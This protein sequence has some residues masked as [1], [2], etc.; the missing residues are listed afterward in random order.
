[1]F[2][3]IYL[4]HCIYIS[5]HYNLILQLSICP[6]KCCYL[7]PSLSLFHSL[8]LSLSCSVSSCCC[9]ASWNNYLVTMCVRTIVVS[10]KFIID[11]PLPF[12]PFSC[13]ETTPL[14]G[15]WQN[16]CGAAHFTHKQAARFHFLLPSFHLPSTFL[17]CLPSSAG[18]L[19]V[20]F[21]NCCVSCPPAKKGC[22]PFRCC[23][24]F[25][26]HF[27]FHIHIKCLFHFASLLF[28][29]HLE[30]VCSAEPFG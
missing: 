4:S 20:A 9:G 6:I 19:P 17:L 24:F 5:C 11:N 7:P 30:C 21:A 2:N 10:N 27:P 15:I 22:F 25:H 23:C 3:W 12:A 26:F 28:V 13:S 29:L 18:Q 8:P 1:M 14:L 16:A